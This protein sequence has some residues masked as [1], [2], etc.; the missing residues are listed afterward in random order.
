MKKTE[1]I[2]IKISPEMKSKLQE[3]ADEK[4][5]TL[6]HYA[7]NLIEK[8]LESSHVIYLPK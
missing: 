7:R 6:S 3:L 1:T 2:G 8:A 4:E 5:W